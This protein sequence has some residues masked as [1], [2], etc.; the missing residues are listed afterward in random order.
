MTL[1]IVSQLLAYI[2]IIVFAIAVIIRVSRYLRMPIH[3]RWE[4]YPVPHEVGAKHGGSYYE[5]EEWW[6]KQRRT[7]KLNELKDM[8]GEMLFIRRVYT[9]NRGLWWFT[10]PFHLGIYLMLAWFALLIIGAF[11]E[12]IGIPIIYKGVVNPAPWSTLIYYLTILVGSLGIILVSCGT[13]GLLI[14]RSLSQEMR[15]YSSLIDYFNLVFI[16]VVALTGAVSW[17]MDMDFTI[18]REYM[19]S[20][21]TFTAI[22][23]ISTITFIH[24]ILLSLL[25][26][27]IP[28]TKMLHF[29]AKYFTYHQ[30]L[31]EDEP[32]IRGGDIEGKVT[33]VLKYKVS[34]KAPHVKPDANWAEEAKS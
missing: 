11:T 2:A 5:E 1:L 24:V 32:N 21:I 31:W 28:F 12:V 23:S 13:L 4:L 27:Y 30:V 6:K 8:L 18:A 22:P 19:K 34:W 25:F 29:V 14:K 9:Y 10:Y 16:L 15:L 3:L 20:L 7:S 33:R 17:R 26:L